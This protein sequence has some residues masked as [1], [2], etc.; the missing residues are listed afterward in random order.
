MDFFNPVLVQFFIQFYSSFIQFYSSFI[1]LLCWR[2][3]FAS[4]VL[5]PP[6]GKKITKINI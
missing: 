5:V 4:D 1:S 2:I 3:L 6:G